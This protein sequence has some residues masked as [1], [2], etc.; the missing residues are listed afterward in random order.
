MSIL[1]GGYPICVTYPSCIKS[2]FVKPKLANPNSLIARI[3]KPDTSRISI[4]SLF[5][6]VMKRSIEISDQTDGALYISPYGGVA[7]YTYNWST[8]SM[9]QNAEGLAPGDY[10]LTITDDNLCTQNFL[11]TISMSFDECLT[12]PNTFTPNG[13]EFNQTFKPIFSEI[14]S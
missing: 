11:F 9:E 7:P 4:D 2:Y 8:G 3:N 10:D 12:I 13:D 6:V 1:S 14:I 5:Y